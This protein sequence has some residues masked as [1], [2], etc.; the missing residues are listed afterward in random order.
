[1]YYNIII[2]L[3]LTL[4]FACS[5]IK[6]VKNLFSKC[7]V[8]SSDHVQKSRPADKFPVLDHIYFKAKH[9]YFLYRT[10]LLTTPQLHYMVRCKNSAEAYGKFSENG[11]YRKLAA[12]FIK[13]QNSVCLSLT[14]VYYSLS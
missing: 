4:P 6:K 8:Y 12:A 2:H 3:N 11:Y 5:R 10:G 13:L 1:M 7:F 9:Q 14:C